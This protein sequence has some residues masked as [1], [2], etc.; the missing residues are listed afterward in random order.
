MCTFKYEIV[1]GNSSMLTSRNLTCFE[2]LKYWFKGYKVIK[3][4]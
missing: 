3:L 4:T 2:K 1:R